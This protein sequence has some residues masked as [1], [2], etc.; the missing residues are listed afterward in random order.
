MSEQNPRANPSGRPFMLP[1]VGLNPLNAMIFGADDADEIPMT[2][3]DM[4]RIHLVSVLGDAYCKLTVVYHLKT[5]S[6]PT[7]RRI[8]ILDGRDVFGYVEPDLRPAPIEPNG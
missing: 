3:P 8:L 7:S 4:P 2:K 6:M 1:L 5:N